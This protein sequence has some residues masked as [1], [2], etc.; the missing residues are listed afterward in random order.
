MI[1]VD[2]EPWI[3][4]DLISLLDWEAMGFV[5]V[6]SSSDVMEVERLVIQHSP[7]LILCDIRMPGMSGLELMEIVKSNHPAVVFLFMSAYSEFSYAVR[8]VQLGAFDYLIKPV[9]ADVLE[10]SLMRAKTAL[11]EQ[12]RGRMKT[13]I[14]QNTLLM[15]DLLD[16]ASPHRITAGRLA[17]EGQIR[18]SGGT[19]LFFVVQTTNLLSANQTQEQLQ[20][21][22]E[23]MGA[24]NA[25][26]TTMMGQTGVGK[27]FVLI[28]F[29]MNDRE[30]K[31]FILRE[32]RPLRKQSKADRIAV[33]VSSP[34]VGL[35]RIRQH[36]RE[37]ERMVRMHWMTGRTGV[38]IYRQDRIGSSIFDWQERI[39]QTTRYAELGAVLQLL[40][41][42]LHKDGFDPDSLTVVY[43]DTI[44]HLARLDGL[45][46]EH[47]VEECPVEELITLYKSPMEL[48]E[49]LHA[50]VQI[51][52]G[53]NRETDNRIVLEVL[54]EIESNYR[55]RLSL[56]GIAGK[57]F[58]NANYLSQLFKLKSGRSFKQHLVETRLA[59][60]AELLTEG[61]LSLQEISSEVGYDDYFHFSKLFK[62][63]RGVSPADLRKMY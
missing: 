48:F 12:T 10:S 45:L 51:N 33:G 13:R 54:Q 18:P 59:K 9:V 14:M 15:L 27:W 41:S 40:S 63:Y 2:D 34:F 19:Y 55:D 29:T 20:H 23:E 46:K 62:K 5:I 50:T 1:I 53:Q 25:A 39:K 24:C 7:D 28:N 8:A 31:R 56:T 38:Y 16:G 26:I 43:N 36:Y 4:K 32:F 49:E 37:A 17:K 6:A 44:R 61:K 52:R 30:H 58:I 11:A 35:D 60:A 3:V 42:R 47:E 22:L 21:G 57:H